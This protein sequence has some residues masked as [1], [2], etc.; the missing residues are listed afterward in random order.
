MKGKVNL[1]QCGFKKH[2]NTLKTKQTKQ[3]TP[4]NEHFKASSVI[5]MITCSYVLKLVFPHHCD[6]AGITSSPLALI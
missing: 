4:G 2:V 1:Q 3:K 5:E 6:K